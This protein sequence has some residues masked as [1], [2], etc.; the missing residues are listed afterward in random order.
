MKDV[1]EF[2]QIGGTR[3]CDMTGGLDY[4]FQRYVVLGIDPVQRLYL[5]PW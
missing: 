1:A 4:R 2:R 3:L 5:S